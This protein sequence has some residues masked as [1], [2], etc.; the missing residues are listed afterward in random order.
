MAVSGVQ[1]CLACGAPL[2]APV[3]GGRIKCSFCGAVNIAKAHE[4]TQG[5]DI[6]CPECGAANP[7]LAKHCGRC[8]IKLE[9]NCP[10]CD[11]LN[12]YGTVYCVQCGVDIPGE[13]KRQQEELLRQQEEERR[14]QE[15]MR[16]RIE[17]ERKRQRISTLVITILMLF[18]ALCIVGVVGIKVYNSTYSPAAKSTKAAFA[19]GETATAVYRV[20]VKDDFSDLTS[21]WGDYS[22][23]NGSTGYENGGFRIHVIKTNWAIFYSLDNKV[24]P[25][26]IRIEVQA[27]KIGGPGNNNFGIIC[28]LQDNKN[29]YYFT[30]SSDGYAAIFKVSEGGYEVISSDTKKWYPV[31]SVHQGDA[32]NNIRADCI[33]DSLTLYVNGVK[34]VTGADSTFTNGTV[35]LEAGTGDVGGT[36]IM[37][38]NFSVFRP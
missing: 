30:I 33:G 20:L 14:S 37:F 2:N 11:A 32:T 23:D 21:G 10:K 1:I 38:D 22:N 8:G 5:D 24:F 26:D 17:T 18:G 36:D 29:F 12:S 25:E 31:S 34:S 4:K 6:I 15:E 35:G 19:A 7:K 28:R 27:T 9:F 13:V 16:L 3:Q